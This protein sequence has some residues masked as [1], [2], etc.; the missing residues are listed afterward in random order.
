MRLDLLIA[1]ISKPTK[2]IVF[3]TVS[4][5]FIFAGAV[6]LGFTGFLWATPFM[7]L[8]FIIIRD[9][10]KRLKYSLIII[11]SMVFAFFMWDKPTNKLIF[12]YLGAKV[13]LVSGWGY[14]GAAYSN[15]FYLIKPDNIENWR[16]RSHTNDPFEVVL[17]DENVTLTMDRVEISH[18]SFG[19]S[20]GV[21]FTDANGNEFYISPDSLINSVAIG[22]ILSEQLTGVESTQSA[23]S[24]NIGLLM[25]WPMLPVILFSKM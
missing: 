13:E 11:V 17:F 21:I 19:L 1:F 7:V 25:A 16:Q 20:L 10:H 18:P 6:N 9:Y 24:N 8:F 3:L 14:Q 22:D 5:L 2:D 23:W 12:P 4:L 15:Q